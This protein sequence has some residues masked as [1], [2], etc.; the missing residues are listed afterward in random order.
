MR[1]PQLLGKARHGGHTHPNPALGIELLT[2]FGQ[3][4]IGLGL[5]HTAH[6]GERRLIT[7][8]ASAASV[9][10]RWPR[11]CNDAAEASRQMTG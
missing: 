7:A 4:G 8:G 5:D 9:G 11:W 1:E 2:Q 6:E 3:G 10:A